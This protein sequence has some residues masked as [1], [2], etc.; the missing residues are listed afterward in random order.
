MTIP[1]DSA[2][3]LQRRR[4][5]GLAASGTLAGLASATLGAP[6]SRAYAAVNGR[7]DFKAVVIGSGFGGAVSALRLGQAGVDTLILERGKEW[8]LSDTQAV[9]GSSDRTDNRMFWFRNIANWPAVWPVPMV[10][11]P[12]VM[13]VDEDNPDIDIACGAAVGGGSIVYTGVTLEPPRKYF[14]RL[15]P[16]LSYD[17]F[18]TTWYPK[19]RG[20]LGSA[21][22]PDDVLNSRPW[23]HS[24][25][26]EKHA[27]AAGFSTEKIQTVFDWDVIRREL[28]GAVR[29]SASI[30]ETDFGCSNGAKRSLTRSYLPAAIATGKVQLQSLAEVQRI[31]RTA[32]GRWQVVVKQMDAAGNQLSVDTYTSELLFVCAGTLNT[33][34]LL[35]AARDGGAL[36]NL[37][38]DVGVGFGDNGDQFSGYMHLLE[39][40]GNAQGSACY[41]GA[42]IDSGLG[43][44]VRAEGW[45]LQAAHDLPIAMT[46]TMT[47]DFDNRGTFR[48]DRLTGKVTLRDW[49]AAKA[50]PSADAARAFNQR[51]ID[52]NPGVVPA[53]VVWPFTLTAHPLGGMVIGRATDWEGRVK[54]YDKLYVLD[55]SLIPGTVGGANPSLSITALAERSISRIIAAG[56]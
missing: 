6:G 3:P 43:V 30:G 49:T 44:P 14:E 29:A 15:Y 37:T 36:P 55:G 13:E 4:F 46:L 8:P 1:D 28:A 2:R 31:G 42:F 12:G 9:F 56:R 34:R 38:A 17:E 23:T 7:T 51:M 11:A 54:G 45:Q 27:K 19:A 5:L 39:A 10:P 21:T 48:Y 40:A 32:N 50:Q 41:S 33:N 47:V 25:I 53:N 35:V 52:R 24:R 20:V 18:V 26:W 22:M 16:Q